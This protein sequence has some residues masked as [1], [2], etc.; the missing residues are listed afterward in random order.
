MDGLS[1]T[2]LRDYII[3]PRPKSITIEKNGYPSKVLAWALMQGKGWHLFFC[4]E[5]P[6][7]AFPLSSM[8]SEIASSSHAN[9]FERF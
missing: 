1:H 5:A 2:F 3:F 9:S 7:L 8:V 4:S 6:G